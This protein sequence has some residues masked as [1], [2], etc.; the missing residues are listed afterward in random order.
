MPDF[1]TDR[2]PDI[3]RLYNAALELKTSDRDAFLARA[4]GGDEPLRRE[5]RSLLDYERAAD[6][7]LERPAVA[8]AAWSI[9]RE[10][11]P[12]LS[13][14]RIAG[15][16]IIDIIGA[17]G[18]GEVYRARDRRLGREVAFKVLEPTIAADPE[19][20]QRFEHEAQSASAL[21]HPNIV[22]I[23]NVAEE[24]DV[25]FITMELVQGKTLR[26]LMAATLPLSTVIDVSVQLAAGLSAAHALGIVHRDLKPENV[27]VTPEG[28]VKVLDFGIAKREGFS[29]DWGGTVGTLAYMSPEQALG[30]PAGPPSDQFTF[31]TVLYEMLT[32][33][34]A[35]LRESKTETL[36]AIVSIEPR[37]IHKL[38]P[39]VPPAVR[40]IIARCLAKQPEARYADTRDLELALRKIRDDM[41]RWPTRRQLLWLGA[42]TA[43]ATVAGGTTWMLWPPHTL[44]VLPFANA[45]HN[46]SAEYLCQGLTQTLIARMNHLPLAVKSFS[47]VSN[48]ARS[49]SNPRTLGKQLGVEKVVVGD[50]EVDA[51]RLVV[52]A[53]LL[54]VATGTS[55]WKQRYD[56][57][58]VSFFKLWDELATAIVDDGLHLRLTRDERRELLSRPTDNAEAFDL[59]L[60]ARR[61][62]FGVTEE[63]Y[64]AARPLL[65]AAVEKD[66]RFAEAW[67]MLAGNYWNCVLENYMPP[68]DGW[69]QVDRCLDRVA[70]LGPRLAASSVGRAN[71]SFYADWN[72][73]AA[74]R[75]WRIGESA[76]DRD[77]VP[78]ALATHALAAWAV[79]DVR[80]ALRLVGRARV[81][82]PMTPMFVLHEASYLLYAGQAEPAAARCLTV[83]NTHP[84]EST[85]Y[86][87][88]AEV[89]RAQGRFD[90]AIAALRK[91]HAL[92]DDSDDELVAAFDGASGKDG[93]LRIERTAVERL[94]LRTLV[95]RARQ[96]YAS[97]VDFARAY[98]QLGDKERA[99]EYLDQALAERSPGLVFLNVDRAWE[100]IRSDSR[101]VAAVRHVGLPS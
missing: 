76:P 79:G 78:E 32:G 65:Q 96:A 20:R 100:S 85:A 14:R 66:A 13:G 54:D 74:D 48:F 8:E 16:D 50:V 42:G 92:R 29:V 37:P 52:R 87:T 64:L 43:A 93:Y 1:P 40:Q 3:E 39:K 28:L 38:N 73:A 51:G 30:V 36:E 91:A 45:A 60:Q 49:Q 5:V 98:A 10:T 99:F 72:W 12:P 55:I 23:Y 6:R 4:C 56:R 70:A 95:R 97:P 24:D 101:F 61:F 63:D 59:Y 15:Y 22:T 11:R 7:F 67:L 21:N 27:M 83:I 25:T 75:W 9:A 58:T 35:F 82:D 46:E 33:Q 47:L 68:A 71:K 44:A 57:M 41:S 77:I 84:D 62:Q 86:F 89:R 80:Q 18:M 88:L 34:H 19:Y 94:E 31:G 17:G 90:D 2:W 53:E 69:P 81:I 26:H